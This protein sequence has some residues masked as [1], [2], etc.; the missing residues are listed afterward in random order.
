MV[1][2]V[3]KAGFQNFEYPYCMYILRHG[4]GLCVYME[5]GEDYDES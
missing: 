4:N 5:M 2:K 1:A 3:R